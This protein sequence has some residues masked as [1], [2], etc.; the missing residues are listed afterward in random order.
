M[1]PRY[2]IYIVSKGRWDTRM[3]SKALHTM[4]VPHYVVVESQEREAYAAALDASATILVL[5]PA[6]QRDYETCDDLGDTKGKGPGPARNY[7]DY[8]SFGQNRLRKVPGLV[9]PQG[10]NDYGMRF[11]VKRDGEWTPEP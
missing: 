11:E 5:D 4:G 7:V 8:R 10:V 1:N 6:Y 9:I 2:P 3:T